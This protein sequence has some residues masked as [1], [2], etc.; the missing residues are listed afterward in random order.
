MSLQWPSF[1]KPPVQARR[2][3][4]KKKSKRVAMELA[5]TQAPLA[6]DCDYLIRIIRPSVIC[7]CSSDLTGALSSVILIFKSVWLVRLKAARHFGDS[8][9][10]DIHYINEKDIHTVRYKTSDKLNTRTRGH[11]LSLIHTLESN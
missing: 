7:V 8:L 4:G 3:Q 9:L 5:V 1:K 6:P 10:S 2:Y 11:R